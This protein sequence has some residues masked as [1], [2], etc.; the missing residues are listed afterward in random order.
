M[1]RNPPRAKAI[2]SAKQMLLAPDRFAMADCGI[3][4]IHGPG[5]SKPSF[6]AAFGFSYFSCAEDTPSRQ[7]RKQVCIL[8]S[9]FRTLAAP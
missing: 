5:R 2:L 6:V 1:T 7:N 8:P 4:E 3:S 9:A